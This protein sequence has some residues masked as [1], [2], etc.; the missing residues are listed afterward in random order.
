MAQKQHFFRLGD[1]VILKDSG[2]WKIDPNIR[3]KFR[4]TMRVA[5]I[6]GNQIK[7]VSEE[8]RVGVKLDASHLM[9]DR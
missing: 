1:H 9:P 2:L 3:G 6:D 8:H 7:V 4:G 5:Q